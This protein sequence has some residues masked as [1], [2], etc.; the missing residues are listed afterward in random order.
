M[1]D[2][3]DQQVQAM[4]EADKKERERWP[5]GMMDLSDRRV[6]DMLEADKQEALAR[7]RAKKLRKNVIELQNFN[8]PT[9]E[10]RFWGADDD[11]H[12][13]SENE[14]AGETR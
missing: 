9:M 8:P 14:W 4:L 6:Q 13:C 2:M 11:W 7:I 12:K 10:P 5:M 3:S 1:M